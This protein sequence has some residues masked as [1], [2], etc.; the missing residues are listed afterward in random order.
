MADG[1]PGKEEDGETPSA[2]GQK[3]QQRKGSQAAVVAAEQ[4]QDS[5][6][7]MRHEDSQAD[8]E[9]NSRDQG[10]LST[11]P[12]DQAAQVLAMLASACTQ[13]LA[14][15]DGVDKPAAKVTPAKRASGSAAADDS[16]RPAKLARSSSNDSQQQH[17]EQGQQD[18]TESGGDGDAGQPDSPTGSDAVAAAASLHKLSSASAAELGGSLAAFRAA[19]AA[20]ERLNSAAAAA[21]G[22]GN[23]DRGLVSA[24]DAQLLLG[25]LRRIGSGMSNVPLGSGGPLKPGQSKQEPH[26]I[27]QG[28]VETGLLQSYSPETHCYVKCGN[29][30]GVFALASGSI[31]CLCNECSGH[32]PCWFAPA[33]FE[34]HG[35]MAASKKWRGSIQVGGYAQCGLLRGQGQGQG[36]TEWASMSTRVL[37]CLQSGGV[38]GK[39]LRHNTVVR[40]TSRGLSRCLLADMAQSCLPAWPC[41]VNSCAY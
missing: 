12:S 21:G 30:Q 29:V 17:E 38:K 13:P 5:A 25:G 37:Q 28:F 24:A 20:T 14:A 1:Q 15:A 34:R 9:H 11:A 39:L 41:F 8:E 7:I 4:K 6:G 2:A 16:G 40:D 32:E 27:M 19:V 33:A 23:S 26:D 18:G 22:G 35:G 3:Q 36:Q 31:L 10:L